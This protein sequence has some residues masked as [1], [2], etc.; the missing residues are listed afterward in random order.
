M[1]PP[2][3][4]ARARRRSGNRIASGGTG[5][6]R[7]RLQRCVGWFGLACALAGVLVLGGC[8]SIYNPPANQPIQ[9]PVAMPGL[10]AV[11]APPADDAL[12]ILSFSGGGTRAAA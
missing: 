2:G 11:S 9:S 7:A 1:R 8:A 10:A 6:W 3:L 4:C 5:D 12:L